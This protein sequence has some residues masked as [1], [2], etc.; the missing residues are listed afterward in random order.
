M[1][2]VAQAF[3]VALAL[4][5][6]TSCTWSDTES[7]L[8]GKRTAESPSQAAPARSNPDL[9]VAGETTWTSAEGA[10]V[11]IRYAVHAVRRTAGMTVLDWSITPLSAPDR[12][13]GDELPPGLDLGL[14]RPD[15]GGISIVLLDPGAERVYRPLVSPGDR[16]AR[17]CLCTPLWAAL[18]TLR[19]GETR[20]LQVAFPPLPE[21]TRS[22]DVLAAT[23]PPFSHVLVSSAGQVPTATYP[24]ELGRPPEPVEPLAAAQFLQTAEDESSR[25]KVTLRVDQVLASTTSTTVRWTLRSMSEQ[26]AFL[27]RPLGPPL[28]AAERPGVPVISSNALSGPTLAAAT[29]KPMTVR[30]MTGN[31]DGRPFL[32]CLCTNLDFWATGLREAGNAAQLVGNYPP[33]PRGT[34]Q[35]DLV[36][37]GVATLSR[38]PVA[39]APDGATR[40]GPPVRVSVQ[41]WRYDSAQPQPGWSS[42]DWPT[43]VPEP[44]QVTAYQRRIDRLAT[45]G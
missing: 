28:V 29:G 26:R 10:Q 23:L 42:A 20:L 7:G 13:D 37:P 9:P 3:A 21:R 32:E 45:Y 1:R 11:T 39:A 31:V 27:A 18:R 14:D 2:V 4:F 41:T 22:V 5:I 30:W 38:L 24:A 33:L 36:I 44:G 34:D 8:F 40:V 19:L 16:G 17:H 6:L 35:V 43:P 12:Q 15:D 25:R